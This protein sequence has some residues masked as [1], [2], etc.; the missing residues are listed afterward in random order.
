MRITRPWLAVAGLSLL[1]ASA[2]AE[3]HQT[4]FGLSVDATAD[5]SAP[6]GF[7]HKH[8]A[9]RCAIRGHCGKQG[10]FGSELPCPDNGLAEEPSADTR[11]TLMS[12]CGDKWAEGPVCCTDEQLGA[13]SSNLKRAESIIGACPA[14]KDNFFNLFCTFTC[15]PDQ[16]LFVNVTN[17]APK[18]DKL[19]V[20]ELD[21]LISEDYGSSF[22]NSC[23]DVKFGATG[24]KA[25][26]L[27][28]P[29][30]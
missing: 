14:C 13:L 7:T 6:D 27:I 30:K 12:I 20:T 10:F 21:Q 23:K 11:K 16:S 1:S 22:Y 25:M 18:G 28:V 26:D 3:K 29:S 5:V 19:L 2:S 4:A 17:I 9:G 8:E 15:S 24:G